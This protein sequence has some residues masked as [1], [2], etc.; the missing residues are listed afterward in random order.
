MSKYT[1]GYGQIQNLKQELHNLDDFQKKELRTLLNT[2][3]DSGGYPMAS[4]VARELRH[5]SSISYNHDVD[6]I[7][8]AL[9]RIGMDNVKGL[10]Q[11]K[12][13]Y[14]GLQEK[15]AS[16]KTMKKS[17]LQ[18]L[19]A[20]AVRKGVQS[21]LTES[22]KRV[23]KITRTQLAEGVRKALR[24]A[25]KENMGMAGGAMPA[26][27]MGAGAPTSAPTTEMAG[28]Q[29]TVSGGHVPSPDELQQAIDR[30]GG[31]EMDLQGADSMAFDYAMHVAGL[32][33]PDMNTGE[34]M[35]AALTALMQAPP[36]DQL[37]DTVDDEEV[38]DPHSQFNQI[39]D[40]WDARYGDKPIEETAADIASSIMGVLGWESV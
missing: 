19:V 39:L 23:K 13:P 22:P 16:K 11:P 34:G 15:T 3:R 37:P 8:D 10:L 7:A 5:M 29:I 18:N 32:G 2:F 33:Y 1:F 40:R 12:H 30:E 38:Q 26:P 27:G 25:M 31:W 14:R 21:A 28:S 17:E 36:P 24:M 9:V 35:H 6:T 4:L 20:E